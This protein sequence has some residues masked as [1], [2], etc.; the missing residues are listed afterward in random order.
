MNR[1]Y[2]ILEIKAAEDGGEKR[3]FQGIATTPTADRS[4][5]I[6][7]PKGAV[8]KLPIPFLWQHDSGDPIGWITS[9]TVTDKGI[10]VEGEIAQVEEEG[11]LKERL[12]M[13]WQML[14]AKLVRGLSIGFRPLESARIGESWSYRFLSWEWLELSGVTIPANLEATITSIKSID[15]ALLAATGQSKPGVV[16]LFSPGASG[17]KSAL[18]KSVSL[19]PAKENDMNLQDQIKRLTDMRTQKATELSAIQ[20]KAATEGRTKDASEREAFEGLKAEIAQI[21]EELE[22]LKSLEAL[23]VAKATPAVGNTPAGAAESRGALATGGAPYI[24]VKRDAEE[25]FKGQNYT[26][27][28]IAKAIA[29]LNDCSP[30]AVAMQRWGKSNPTLVEVVKAAVTGGGSDSGEWGA[31]L[32][33]ANTQYMGDFIEYLYS[34]TV[35]DKLPLRQIPAN[36]LIKGQDGAATGYWVGESKPIPASTVDFANVTLGPLKVAALA[37]VSNEL[38]RDSTPA[39]EMLVRDALVQASAQ[40]VDQTFL[41]TA[42]KSEGVSPAGILNGLTAITSNGTDGAGVRAD[43]KALYAPFITAK[44]A[45]GLQFVTSPS[46]AKAIQLMVN[47]LGQTEFQG[48]TATGGTLLGDPTVTGDNVGS[49]QLILL[50]PSDIYRIGDY[51]IEVSI[52]REAAIEQDTSPTGATDTPVGMTATNMTSMFQ[53]E[54]TAIKVVRPIN[55]AKRRASAVAYVSGADYGAAAAAD[56]SSGA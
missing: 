24:Q 44:N 8:F 18:T 28:V 11:P 6:V 37:V 45:T 54:S 1:A 3:T 12:D 53:S 32:V 9:A 56:S 34:Q 38:L 4:G 5:D 36:V 20:E 17:T 22:D 27:M 29:R 2:S 39:A 23:N 46:L 33:Q 7:E 16:R 19:I 13:A 14:K 30:V 31:E 40:R 52:S 21:D 55:F 51:G 50:K 48:I 26:R 10:E 41:S 49:D 25:K 35:Y 42:A 47:A 43:V 15:D